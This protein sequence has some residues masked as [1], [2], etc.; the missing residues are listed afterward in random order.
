MEDFLKHLAWVGPL[1]VMA[2]VGLLAALRRVIERKKAQKPTLP[3][4]RLRQPP[5]A[6]SKQPVDYDAPPFPPAELRTEERPGERRRLTKEEAAIH[7]AM[8]VA[9]KAADAGEPAERFM[10]PITGP[11]AGS[12]VQLGKTEYIEKPVEGE[13]DARADVQMPGDLEQKPIDDGSSSAM[14]YA[15]RQ[16]RI[17]EDGSV[18]HGGGVTSHPLRPGEVTE[19]IDG[20]QQY[21]A[22]LNTKAD[23]AFAEELV[24]IKRDAECLARHKFLTPERKAQLLAQERIE[25]PEEHRDPRPDDEVIEA[26]VAHC[27]QAAV[28]QAKGIY[29]SPNPDLLKKVTPERIRSGQFFSH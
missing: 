16:G 27:V 1:A 24:M 29:A 25:A 22:K 23:A 20:Y 15:R 18:D 26:F 6:I 2:L 14:R 17:G 21:L 9:T 4:E 19:R 5:R 11:Q 13:R 12:V 7:D 3:P 8:T 28:D 10:V